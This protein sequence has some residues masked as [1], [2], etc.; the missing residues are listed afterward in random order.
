[1]NIG[2]IGL[3]IMGSRMAA[4]LLQAGH[5]LQVF[6]RDATKCDALVDKGALKV[7]SPK[8]AAS[9]TDFVITMV[10]D[11]IAVAAVAYGDDGVL[12]GISNEAIWI[13]CSTIGQKESLALG[14]ACAGAGKKF[15]E[16]PVSGSKAPAESGDL[17]FLVGGP[18]E[19]VKT[20]QPL[21]DV[22]GAKTVHV[23]KHGSAAALKLVFNHILGVSMVAFAE[24]L[25]LGK[26]LDIAPDKLFETLLATPLVAPYLAI[27]KPKLIDGELEADFPLKWMNKDLALV[28][29]AAYENDVAMPLANNAKEVYRL[30]KLH[31]HGEHDFAAVFQY[32]S[33]D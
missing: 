18:A 22:M 21:F 8:Q 2:F 28:C 9:N 17:T 31:G 6:N 5:K 1:M 25:A 29:D 20:A 13:D 7:S 15:L 11:P 24:G 3:G 12:A 19:F 27:K 4:N 26:S 10:S 33:G 14:A 32:L 16:A 30:A 23:G